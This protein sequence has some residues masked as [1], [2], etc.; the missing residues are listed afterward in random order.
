M[1][2]V[3]VVSYE[4]CINYFV[5][6]EPPEFSRAAILLQKI[7]FFPFTRYQ[8]IQVYLDAND[9]VVLDARGRACG[10]AF[11]AYSLDDEL[12]HAFGRHKVLIVE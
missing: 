11:S 3:S 8:I 4:D 7:G 9:E 6:N 1:P 5:A 12:K 2:P 10:R